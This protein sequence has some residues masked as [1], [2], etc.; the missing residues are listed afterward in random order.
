MIVNSETR[1]ENDVDAGAN[2][3]VTGATTIG[4]TLG[5]TGNT[6]IGGTL[7][8][9]GG[10][11]QLTTTQEQNIVS[12]DNVAAAGAVM[13]TDSINALSD[14]DTSSSLN[15]QVLVWNNSEGKWK[16]GN[17]G[18][19]LQVQHERTEGRQSISVVNIS[20]NAADI[21]GLSINFT[22]KKSTSKILLTAMINANNRSTT[23]FGFKKNGVVLA[24]PSGTNNNSDGSIATLYA[25]TSS[26]SRM[27]NTYIEWL[28]DA[29]NTNSRT[30]NTAG[31]SSWNG[32]NL[33]LFINNRYG[34]DTASFSSMTIYEIQQ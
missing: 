21:S 32:N 17:P 13:N 16:P 15:G 6:T 24:S 34:N 1:F 3:D 29:N 27:W 4:G 19:I 30:Y 33:Y 14:V 7:D 8:V 9:T 22:P 31:C 2:L 18:V 28:D 12:I 26:Q 11:I 23:T 10:S 25:G 20:S 5:V